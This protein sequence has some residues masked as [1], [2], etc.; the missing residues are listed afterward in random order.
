[1][2]L[3]KRLL[4]YMLL[5]PS[6]IFAW[7]T[8][9]LGYGINKFQS[10]TFYNKNILYGLDF[11]HFSLS[12]ETTDVTY[13]Q[14]YYN[15][16]SDEGEMSINVFMPRLGYRIPMKNSGKVK[17][18]NQIEGYLVLP[19]IT[20]KGNFESESSAN[21]EK[22]LE[23]A[24]D[25]MGFKL[26]HIVE[27]MFTDQFSLSADVGL[28]WMFHSFSQKTTSEVSSGNSINT[29]TSE[30]ELK[31]MLGM[32]YTKFTLHFKLEKSKKGFEL[33]EPIFN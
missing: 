5:L 8:F 16:D 26:S 32:T 31:T 29:Q 33:E 14:G 2:Q 21:L 11:L 23:D 4:I 27:Y 10:A 9:S 6:F 7:D 18:F 19:I 3:Q 17:T 15:T 30:L 1:M 22:D 25:L 24:L 28:N 20:L 13:Q 12:N